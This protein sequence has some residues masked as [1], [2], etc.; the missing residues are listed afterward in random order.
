MSSNE[1]LLGE[2]RVEHE[3]IILEESTKLVT[4]IDAS[5]RAK[6]E[7]RANGT[8]VGKVMYPT[9]RPVVS[10][11]NL[12]QRSSE[13]SELRHRGRASLDSAPNG[14]SPLSAD[15]GSGEEREAD[16]SMEVDES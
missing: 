11:G 10:D 4:C 7:A 16:S 2:S 5:R 6:K 13:Q 14:R 12:R 8:P 3:A 15:S 9:P 1:V